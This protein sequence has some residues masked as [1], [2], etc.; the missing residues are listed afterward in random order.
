MPPYTPQAGDIKIRREN[1][2]GRWL[3]AYRHPDNS[4][5]ITDVHPLGFLTVPVAPEL[6]VGV[7]MIR[8]FRSVLKSVEY[9]QVE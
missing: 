9:E 4:F 3:V 8:K 1:V 5:T 7:D 6:Q 2:D